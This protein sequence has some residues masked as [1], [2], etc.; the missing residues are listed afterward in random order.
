MDSFTTQSPDI[1][2]DH[3]FRSGADKIESNSLSEVASSSG[4][5]MN[6]ALISA[7]AKLFGSVSHSLG[8]I[9]GKVNAGVSSMK[10][11][12]NGAHMPFDTH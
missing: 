3:F 9:Q 6:D 4:A 12:G 5:S 7:K 10:G 8:D 11:T 2:Y 1:S